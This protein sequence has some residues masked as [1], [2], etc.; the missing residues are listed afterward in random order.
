MKKLLTFLLIVAC[1]FT[2]CGCKNN[3]ND[4]EVIIKLGLSGPLSGGAQQYG[5]AVKYGATIAVEEIN[6]LNGPFKFELKMEDDEALSEKAP[7]AYGSLV[8]W[9]MQIGLFTV[10]S[11]AGA[12]VASLYDED[13][14][15]ALTPSGSDPSLIYSQTENYEGNFQMCFTDPNQGIASADYIAEN[16]LPKKVAV[17]YR[18]DDSYSTGIYEKFTSEAAVKG[19]EIVFVGT[20]KSNDTD[21]S[22][23]LTQAQSAGAQLVFLPIYYEPASLILSQANNMNYSPIFFG[24]DGMDGILGLKGFDTKLAEGVYLLTPFAAD[25]K[26]EATKHFVDAYKAKCNGEVPNQFAADAYDCVYAIYQALTNAGV[27]TNLSAKELRSIL[28][29]QFT[30]MTFD[31]VTGTGVTW[32]ENGE[33]SKSPKTVIINNGAYKAV[34]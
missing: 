12:A 28:I 9:G 25:A 8:D 19:I 33:V 29:K 7:N 24:V 31:G 2:V 3:E 17:I 18:N 16:N 6:A 5:D 10:T 27:K 30:S 26:D 4:G 32:N 20:F 15:F 21:F 1:L 22:V 13:E 23:Q 14:I 34:E 11:G